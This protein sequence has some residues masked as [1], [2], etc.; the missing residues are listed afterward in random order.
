MRGRHARVHPTRPAL[1]PRHPRDHTPPPPGGATYRPRRCGRRRRRRRARRPC[2]CTPARGRRTSSSASGRSAARSGRPAAG[3][4]TTP[5]ASGRPR[6]AGTRRGSRARRRSARA[7]AAGSTRP[8]SSARRRRG[9]ARAAA[10]RPALWGGGERH[11]GRSGAGK[12]PRHTPS[13]W[14]YL[15]LRQRILDYGNFSRQ[16]VLVNRETSAAKTDAAVRLNL[17]YRAGKDYRCQVN[18][19][20]SFESNRT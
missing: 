10:G 19:C 20:I 9:R 4:R 11:G 6:T 16:K 2:R 13:R 15:G 14:P 12:T 1:A 3:G 17:P 7:A 8:R 18:S 5:A